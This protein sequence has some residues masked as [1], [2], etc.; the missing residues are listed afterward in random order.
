MPRGASDFDVTLDGSKVT[1]TDPDEN[2]TQVFVMEVDGSNAKQLTHGASGESVLLSW[3]P[4]GSMIAYEAD[5]SDESQIFVVRV[6]DGV[7][8]QVTRE[9]RG[10]VD[11]GG[12]TPDGGSI[13]Y[14]TI[15]ASAITTRREPS[16]SERDGRG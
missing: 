2:G 6:A 8:T 16:I 10:A 12:W 11:P 14:S 9:P 1:Y 3:S 7:S 4:D 15:N 13:I 5:T